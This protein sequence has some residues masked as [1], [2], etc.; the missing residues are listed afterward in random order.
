[1][2]KRHAVHNSSEKLNLRHSN[3]YTPTRDCH[4]EE[5]RGATMYNNMKHIRFAD[6]MTAV[7][8]AASEA[9]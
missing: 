3:E 8:A 4:F 2:Y 1:M 9:E 7:A 5:T 6:E